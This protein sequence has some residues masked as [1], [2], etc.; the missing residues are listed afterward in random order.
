MGGAIGV[1]E[2]LPCLIAFRL[3][4]AIKLPAFQLR[5]RFFS[6]LMPL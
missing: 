5:P 2:L 3:L 6:H 4:S 1:R